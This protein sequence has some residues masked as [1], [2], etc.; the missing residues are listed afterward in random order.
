LVNAV[1]LI[2]GR[3]PERKAAAAPAPWVDLIAPGGDG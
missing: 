3:E 1:T 2:G